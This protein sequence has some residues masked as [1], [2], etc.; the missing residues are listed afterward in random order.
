MK[1]IDEFRDHRL[2]RKLADAIRE[3]VLGARPDGQPFRFMEF[4]G[5]HTHAIFRFGLPDLLPPEIKMIHGPGCPVCVLPMAK[6]DA[7]IQLAQ[8][9]KVTLCTY[10]DMMRV[11]GGHRIS[12]MKAKA[13]GCDVRMV[14]SPSEAVLFAKDNPD[15]Q[16]VFF[17]IGF[18]TTT[19]PTAVIL[20]QARE[21][22]LKNFSIFCNHV[23]TP[24]ALQWL[25]ETSAEG[26]EGV[27]P[28]DGFVGPSHVSAI[29]G[30]KPYEIAPEKYGK[31]VV[32]TGFEPLD[33]LQA[34]LML[35][36]QC[37]AGI[38]KVENEY[39]RAVLPEGNV[40]AQKLMEQ[41]F[42]LRDT[43]EWRGLGFIP[44]SALKIRQE[45]AE[46]D[47]EKR[48]EL[49]PSVVK[50]N[51]AC[52]CPAILRGA[53][54]PEEC[55]LFGSVCTPENPIGACMVSSEGGCAAWYA[56][57]RMRKKQ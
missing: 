16:V 47:A 33:V 23:L 32:I 3:E 7:A 52:Q 2:A 10:G 22:G 4:C 49:A 14:T 15:K 18:E 30:T 48:F 39:S 37:K 1:Y 40:K 34:I 26:A 25:L 13:A 57:G 41:A 55:K 20:L 43:F 17:A 6:I 19:P 21:L 11:P 36:R 46:F 12:L 28:L 29:I 54:S 38:A 27:P 31:P 51:P 53:K 44:H 45:Y 50:E 42:E 8:K 24:P 9:H 56:Y 35:V 5:G